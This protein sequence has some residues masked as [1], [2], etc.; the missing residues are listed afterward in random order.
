[1]SPTS[2]LTLLGGQN[3]DLIWTAPQ[4]GEFAHLALWSETPLVHQLAGQAFLDMRGIF[5]TPTAEVLYQGN[6]VQ[7]QI[8]AQFVARRLRVSGQG[9][10]IVR[11]SYDSAVLI[12]DDIVA[13]IR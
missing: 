6:G 1:M 10:L 11:P 2:Q 4:V 8:E 7:Q 5:F 3:G 13:L 12:P 9:V